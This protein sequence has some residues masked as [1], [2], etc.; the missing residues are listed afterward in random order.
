M[1]IYNKLRAFGSLLL[2]ALGLSWANPAGGKAA[3]EAYVLES[4]SSQRVTVAA[5]AYFP[6]LLLLQNGELLATFKVGAGHVGKRG[7][8]A[9]SVSQDGGLTWSAPTV[10]FD[11]PDADDGADAYG[12]LRDGTV[13]L[14]AVSYGWKGER[15]SFDGFYANPYVLRSPDHGRTWSP[16]SQVNIKPFTWAYPFGRI[17]ELPDGVLLMTM[18]AGYLPCAGDPLAGD[19]ECAKPEPHRGTFS[20]LVR[21]TDGGNTWGEAK[22]IARGYNETCPI[23][24]PKGGL[25]VAMRSVDGAFLATAFSPDL[26]RSWS[27]PKPI[28]HN[29]EHPADLLRLRN[30]EILLTFGQ[31]NKPYGVQAMVSRD[32][33][34]TWDEDHRFLLAWDGDHGDVGYPVTV[35]RKDGKLVTIYYIVY[36]AEGRF[37]IEG[38]APDGA[39]TKV[40]IWER[41]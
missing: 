10:I 8:A 39:Y 2:L 12:E 37:K 9:T 18:Q 20:I 33:G 5:G 28:T 1:I 4:L 16:P 17:V 3:P 23:L 22:T 7:R 27:A 36:G 19:K 31:R 34:A 29:N 26:G 40:V 38:D 14:G 13:I 21:S 15:F 25:M 32:N 24:L 41:K 30:G 35:E 11:L 6:R